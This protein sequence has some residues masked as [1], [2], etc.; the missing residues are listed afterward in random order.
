MI[1]KFVL[2][3]GDYKYKREEISEQLITDCLS[4]LSRNEIEFIILEPDKPIDGSR[5]LQVTSDFL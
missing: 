5:F 2:D 3:I 4:K 1:N